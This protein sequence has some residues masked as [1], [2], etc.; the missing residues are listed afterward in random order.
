MFGQFYLRYCFRDSKSDR[1]P[2]LL[3]PDLFHRKSQAVY[4][5]QMFALVAQLSQR[6][7]LVQGRGKY[8]VRPV[9]PFRTT[10]GH[11]VL[12]YVRVLLAGTKGDVNS[13]PAN[14]P[15]KV[16]SALSTKKGYRP[17]L[18]LWQL[19]HCHHEAGLLALTSAELL[20]AQKAAAL[21][22]VRWWLLSSPTHLIH[23][24][25]FGQS[26]VSPRGATP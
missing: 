19:C 8:A 13:W 17:C 26:G 18:C 3:Y 4:N 2:I 15:R 12:F 24:W 16:C 23:P 6:V 11:M 10:L 5:L 22:L 7:L 9:T 25:S 1:V 14:F 20:R 21:L